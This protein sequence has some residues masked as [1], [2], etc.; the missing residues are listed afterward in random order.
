[1]PKS[2]IL[3]LLIAGAA[4]R[5]GG[6]ISDLWLDEIWSLNNSAI[7]RQPFDVFTAIHLDNNHH[8]NTLY[9]AAVG[10][11]QAPLLYRLPAI[12]SGVLFIVIVAV[13]LWSR[14]RIE[15]VVATGLLAFSYPLILYASEARGYSLALLFAAA[16]V[17]ALLRYRR[18]P[19]TR[20]R[21]TFAAFVVLGILSQLTFVFFYFVLVAWTLR[22]PSLHAIPVASLAVLYRVD[23]SRMAIGGGTP[24]G[25]GSVLA[26]L[27]AYT[28][29]SP[30]SA[31]AVLIAGLFVW[32]WRRG[33]RTE[34]GLALGLLAV[35]VIAVVVMKAEFVAVRY[36]LFA[37]PV[38]LLMSARA[39]A[40]LSRTG[41]AGRF[42]SG[43]ILFVFFCGNASRTADL[44][45]YGRGQYREAIRD[46]TAGSGDTTVSS[47][48]DFR[49]RTILDY[50]APA[51]QYVRSGPSEWYIA[52]SGPREQ[53]ITVAGKDYDLYRRYRSAAL[54]GW[55]WSLYR[56][57]STTAIASR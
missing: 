10:P 23:L 30:F 11:R 1:M 49:N 43:F 8:L 34:C 24:A 51:I 3:A 17:L 25:I 39:L 28:L 18:D 41:R 54:S 31:G 42:A 47:D 16:S 55:E 56:R 46:M 38:V 57:S 13:A 40:A 27:V 37:V 32:L 19:T 44:L 14:D 36:F 4:L 33:E 52:H 20:W 48:H 9:L 5:I 7:V 12:V 15:A 22:T 53:H 21:L 35:P 6:G 2:L 26:D 45:R 29:G 50:Y